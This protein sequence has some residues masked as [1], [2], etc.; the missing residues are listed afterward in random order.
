MINL[1]HTNCPLCGSCDARLLFNSK[2][3][4]HPIPGVFPV[5]QCRTCELVYL[6]PRPDDDSLS[7]CY[8][9][10]YDSYAFGIG[11]VGR[12][13]KLL[14]RQAAKKV[15]AYL[16]KGS[17]VLEV[18]CAT[19]DLLAPLRDVAGLEVVGVEL[20]SYAANLAMKN[21][22]LNV[23]IGKL[24]DM[25]FPP[26]SFD[27][28]I[29][30][31]VLEHLPDPLGDLK[32]AAAV[33][34]SGGYIFIDVPNY[35]SLDR[36][37]TGPYW[38]GYSSPR[39]LTI[40]SVNTLNGMLNRAGFTTVDVTH[41]LVPNNWIGSLKNALDAWIGERN[42]FRWVNFRNPVFVLLTAPLGLIQ[43]LLCTSGRIE[44][45]ARKSA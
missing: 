17:R 37:L 29:M 23:R 10:D 6:D 1:I 24:K 28:V 31:N 35:D 41:S 11:T 34:K 22:Q 27:A 30:R 8:P 13:Q 44:V 2:D 16:P 18:G 45:V 33:L 5:V 43:K 19:G 7:A 4:E 20:S 38:Y 39:H 36:R 40:P 3:R 42:R 15:A 26:E 32:R 14:R 12:L 25:V 21:H 9:D